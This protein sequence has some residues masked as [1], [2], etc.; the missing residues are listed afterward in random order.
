MVE[1][2]REESTTQKEA[3]P[4][5]RLRTPIWDIRCHGLVPQYHVIHTGHTH[6]FPGTNQNFS[7]SCSKLNRIQKK[8]GK[9][10]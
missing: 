3:T 8:Y 5:E 10:S 4:L 7:N 1:V 9:R 6:G 2:Q